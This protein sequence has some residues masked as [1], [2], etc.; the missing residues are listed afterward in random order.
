MGILRHYSFR[1]RLT[2]KCK[3][4]GNELYFVDESYT[5]KTCTC[6][7]QLNNSLGSN[8]VFNC[9]SCGLEIDRDINGARN[10]LIK[11]W[12]HIC[13]SPVELHSG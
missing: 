5:S 2:E 12:T 6:C 10:I 4:R 3:Q 9:K 13:E 7:G 8:K 11:N 1:L